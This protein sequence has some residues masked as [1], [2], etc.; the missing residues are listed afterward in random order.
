MPILSGGHACPR[1]APRASS[2]RQ[3]S[4]LFFTSEFPKPARQST[5]DRTA[6]VPPTMSFWALALHKR[7]NSKNGRE[8]AGGST[9]TAR[10]TAASKVPR[11]ARADL[12]MHTLRCAP[13]F[14][15]ALPLPTFLLPL[16]LARL[17]LVPSFIPADSVLFLPSWFA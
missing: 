7:G 9:T 15:T 6:D 4:R 5:G 3:L 17:R 12:T 10:H 11:A 14:S 2:P 8:R 1:P 13:C 16:H